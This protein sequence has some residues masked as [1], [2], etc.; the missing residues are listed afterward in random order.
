MTFYSLPGLQDLFNHFIKLKKSKI[1]FQNIL[2]SGLY[3]HA[4][5]V[6]E[7]DVGDVRVQFAYAGRDGEQVRP[8]WLV[9]CL[10]PCISIPCIVSVKFGTVK[11]ISVSCISL[12]HVFL[13]SV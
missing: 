5:D 8:I 3:F 10:A 13:N 2:F 11:M 1:H 12:L 4:K 6:W 9:L 7:P